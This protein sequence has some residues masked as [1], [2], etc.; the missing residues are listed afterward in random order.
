D[1]T[2]FPQAV[3]ELG[4]NRMQAYRWIAL[5]KVPESRWAELEAMAELAPIGPFALTTHL[6]PIARY[7]EIP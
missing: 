3:A 2:Q 1:V 7:L 4:I 6:R 5:T